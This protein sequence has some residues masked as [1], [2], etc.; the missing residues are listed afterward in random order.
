MQN[1]KTTNDDSPYQI[2]EKGSCEDNQ[3]P[4]MRPHRHVVTGYGTY[5]KY[6]I[7]KPRQRSQDDAHSW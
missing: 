2:M 6:I 5:V 1:R 3:C 4:Y 7:E